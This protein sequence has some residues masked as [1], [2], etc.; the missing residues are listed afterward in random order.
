MCI[1]IRL[2]VNSLILGVWP[3][4]H[5]SFEKQASKIG[6]AEPNCRIRIEIARKRANLLTRKN[7]AARKLPGPRCK[8]FKKQAKSD[9]FVYVESTAYR[10]MYKNTVIL[11]AF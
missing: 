1:F 3:F 5:R 9:E 10:E 7:Q 6:A 8:L 4:G 2:N 11:T